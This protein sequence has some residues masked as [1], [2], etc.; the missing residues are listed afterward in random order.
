ML[1]TKPLKT[2]RPKNKPELK[3]LTGERIRA[4]DTAQKTTPQEKSRVEDGSGKEHEKVAL[5]RGKGALYKRKQ[6]Y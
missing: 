1:R 2:G 5:R 3:T 4:L 6:S